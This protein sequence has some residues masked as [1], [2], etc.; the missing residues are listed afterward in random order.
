[1]GA[2]LHICRSTGRR[3]TSYTSTR[4]FK[5]AIINLKVSQK[6]N[7]FAIVTLNNLLVLVVKPSSP[8][9]IFEDMGRGETML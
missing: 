2:Y 6:L 4:N 8:A 1:M 7:N 3:S 5:G 9:L